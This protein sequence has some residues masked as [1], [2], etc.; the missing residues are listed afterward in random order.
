MIGFLMAQVV[1]LTAAIAVPTVSALAIKYW[2]KQWNLDVSEKQYDALRTL[3]R[4]AVLAA[5][6]QYAQIKDREA[7]GRTKRATAVDFVV[8]NAKKRNIE[9]DEKLA[10]DLVEAAVLEFVNAGQ[11]GSSSRPPGSES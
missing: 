5:E 10:G 9:V 6:Q 2:S 1:K 11:P 3:S 8:E 7:R 4:S